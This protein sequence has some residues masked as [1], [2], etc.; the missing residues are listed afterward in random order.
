M[1]GYQR[2]R[3]DPNL[4]LAVVY[5][6]GL[7]L[8]SGDSSSDK[9]NRLIL[10]RNRALM[11]VLWSTA[12][13]VDEVLQLRCNDVGSGTAKSSTV[14]AKGR[15]PH[16]VF[17]DEETRSAIRA[18]LEERKRQDVRSRWLFVGHRTGRPRSPLT[19]ATAWSV[20]K[21]AAEA[22]GLVVPTSPH[23][24]RHYRARQY[25][26]AGV[27]LETIQ[28]ILGHADV[29]T[30]GKVYAP[31]DSAAVRRAVSEHG[32]SASEA[33]QQVRTVQEQHTGEVS[34]DEG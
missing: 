29:T 4:P 5:Y 1:G 11:H 32:L 10:L 23:S 17:L 16:D 8:P 27:S 13:R 26:R 6:D 9:M 2:R 31:T 15:Q 20:V 21:E 34:G 3:V 28:D 24:I 19:R 22:V 12:A 14:R 30:T 7:A 25:R 33:A 18:Y